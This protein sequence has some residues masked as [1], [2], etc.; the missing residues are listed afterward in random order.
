MT[1]QATDP[2]DG[3]ALERYLA[4]A[5]P[6]HERAMV[7]TWL[8][9]EPRRRQWAE[10]LRA[11]LDGGARQGD[12]DPAREWA[13]F[14]ARMQGI[15][16]TERTQRRPSSRLEKR[17]PSVLTRF[18]AVAAIVVAAGSV[19]T[20]L[21]HRRASPLSSHITSHTYASG[22]Q[23]AIVRLT[24]GSTIT[25]APRTH[26][27]M[28]EDRSTQARTATLVGDAHFDIESHSRASFAVRTGLVTTR[29]LGTTFDVSYDDEKHVGRVAVTTGRVATVRGEQ[30]VTLSPKMIGRFND[31]TLVA[32]TGDGEDATAYTDWEHRRLVFRNAPLP[33]VLP[34]LE[35]WYGYSFRVTDSTIAKQHI[36]AELTV[37]DSVEM[38]R[39]VRY[40][41]GVQME[42][43]GTVVTLRPS[44]ARRDPPRRLSSPLSSPSTVEVGR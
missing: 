12:V 29:V 19:F 7:E 37:G 33:I 40:I 4:G 44:T 11:R 30:H 25:L 32:V 34:L 23:T 13:R 28:S 1:P 10:L 41:L 18:L 36:T 9:A 27:V 24:D 22:N 17:A 20:Y 2:I 21:G 43:S 39:A 42:F 26:L 8:A 5:S 15:P 38:L 31:S 3:A 14:S 16:E 35:R 6:A